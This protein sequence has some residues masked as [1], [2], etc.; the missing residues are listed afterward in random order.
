MQRFR[1]SQR[2]L[3]PA[4][5]R[6]VFAG[7]DKLT[8]RH[9]IVLSRMNNAAHARLGLAVAKKRLRLA[10]QR[11]RVKRLIRE[12]FRAQAER[13]PHLDLVFMVRSGLERRTGTEL[14]AE[15]KHLFNKLSDGH[16]DHS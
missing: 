16:P 15:L 8:S 4:E 10:V 3:K 13:L 6:H 5:F 9:F 12:Q 1:R 2:I 7:A 11:N 14:A